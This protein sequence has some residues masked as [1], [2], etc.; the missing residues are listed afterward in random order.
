MK[1][2]SA[3]NVRRRQLDKALRSVSSLRQLATPE[4]GWIR[5]IRL[6]LGMTAAQ[7][8]ARLQISQAAVSQLE[9]AEAT[10]AI[11]LSTIRRVAEALGCEMRYVF[12]PA[13]SLEH[14]VRARAEALATQLAMRVNASMALEDQAISG[15][16]VKQQVAELSEELVRRLDREL[17]NLN[18]EP[19]LPKRGNAA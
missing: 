4:R 2:A 8:G 18:S 7:L 15:E 16:S 17:W 19:D 9:N 14:A 10:G 13:D 5:E 6:A 11:S 3:A 1:P 12:L